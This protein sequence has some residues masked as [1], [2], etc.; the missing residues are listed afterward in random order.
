M[1]Q[2]YMLWRGDYFYLYLYIYRKIDYLVQI[3]IQQYFMNKCSKWKPNCDIIL[4]NKIFSNT[5]SVNTLTYTI[6]IFP[7]F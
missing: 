4:L 1:L 7:L 3:Y 6:A 5:Q 2:Y